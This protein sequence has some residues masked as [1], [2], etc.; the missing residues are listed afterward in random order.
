[1]KPFVSA[2]RTRGQGIGSVH[3]FVCLRCNDPRPTLGRKFSKWRGVR[4]Y[5]CAEC[6]QAVEKDRK[7]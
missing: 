4:G 6:A 2:M 1:M 7:P 5:L 3:Q